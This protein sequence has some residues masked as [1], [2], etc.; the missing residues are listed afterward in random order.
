[1]KPTAVDPSRFFSGPTD[2]VHPGVRLLRRIAEPNDPYP[3]WMRARSEADPKLQ[4]PPDGDASG[5]AVARVYGWDL[6]REALRHP[7][8]GL[9]RVYRQQLEPVTGPG[10]HCKDPPEHTRIRSVIEPLF[11]ESV[12]R[13]SDGELRDLARDLLPPLLE[14]GRA[15]LIADFTTEYPPRVI[16]R[17]LGLPEVHRD[18]YRYGSYRFA[19]AY[20]FRQMGAVE[21]SLL[22]ESKREL[23]AYFQALVEAAREGP[24]EGGLLSRLVHEPALGEEE[25]LGFLMHLAPASGTSGMALGS[26]IYGLLTHPAEHERLRGDLSGV[27]RAVEEGLRWEAPFAII[28]RETRAP[29]DLGGRWIPSGTRMMLH[30][31]AANRDPDRFENPHVFDTTRA[32]TGHLSFAA[33]PHVCLGE[34]LARREMRAALRVLYEACSDL[35]LDPD[36]REEAYMGG[37]F[38]RG[39]V[40]LPVLLTS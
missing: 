5:P 7:D 22:Q 17:V 38:W 12:R 8:V 1:M 10:M 14:E 33:G 16:A 21:E 36:R 34:T 28:E 15:E 35:R 26:L 3:A 29:V 20:M 25:I 4:S 37:G 11:R 13:I 39:V 30:I 18:W 19:A 9:S 23:R 32:Q 40:R 31:A 6:V 24:E 2:G 27:P